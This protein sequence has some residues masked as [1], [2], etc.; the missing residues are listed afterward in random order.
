MVIFEKKMFASPECRKKKKF[1]SQVIW[2]PMNIKWPLP[3][4][5]MF[6]RYTKLKRRYTKQTGKT[7]V[8]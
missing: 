6:R 3:K 7:K 5:K 2:P 4:M 1:A 8:K